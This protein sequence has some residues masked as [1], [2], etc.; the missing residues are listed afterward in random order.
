MNETHASEYGKL[1]LVAT[2]IGNLKDITFRAIEI[3]K[4][5]DI[6][7]AEDTRTTGVLLKHYEINTR[8]ES[9][10]L[11]NED[12]KKS[13][14]IQYLLSGKSVALVSDAGTP[15]I[16]DPAYSL[17]REAIDH[18]VEIIP[19]PGA[20]SVLPALIASGLPTDKF[21]FAGF[22]PVKS[23]KRKKLFD[24]YKDNSETIVFFESPHRLIKSLNDMFSVFGDRKCA[25]C[26]ELT[27]KF[28]QIIRG[29]LSEIVQNPESI[30]IKG[31]FVIV[32]NGL[33]DK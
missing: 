28:E 21:I 23:G 14:I 2:P 20:S 18:G 30:K 5:V 31:E 26:R 22:P 32:I 8:K 25:I 24:N 3:L 10:H 11:H 17:V 15:G 29:N 33:R 7:A 16:S 1:Y 13:K 6:I 19:I 27:K 12:K 9:F 4:N